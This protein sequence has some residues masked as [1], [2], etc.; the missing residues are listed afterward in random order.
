[1][2]TWG[3]PVLL[4]VT[5]VNQ[6]PVVSVLM[7]TEPVYVY[8][9]TQL[10]AS[11]WASL[12]A[13]VV[14]AWIGN[15]GSYWLGRTAG[16]AVVG[17]MKV[18]QGAMARAKGMFDRHGAAFVVVA[19]LIWPI[20]TLTQVMSGAWGMRPWTFLVA[21]GLGAVLAIAQYAL[22]GWASA[23]GL[24]ALG[25]RPEE[26]LLAWLGPYLV[27]IGVLAT[28]LLGAVLIL[29][30]GRGAR[31]VRAAYV[32][33][34]ALGM[35]LAV[36]LGALTGHTGAAA[37]EAPIP[38]A[39]A[40]RALDE[41]LVART[42]STPLHSAQPVNLVLVGV[43]DPGAVLEGLGW[44]RNRTYAGEPLNAWDVVGLTLRGLPP[45]S[46]LLLEGASSDL[47]WQQERGTVPRVQLR[48]WPVAVPEGAP[49]TFLGSVV[50][51]DAITLRLS[52]RVPTL[53][54]DLWPATDEARDEEAAAL[55]AALP[56]ASVAP[57]GPETAFVAPDPASG[58][59]P[60]EAF[61]AAVANEF[62]S[63]GRAAELRAPG[64]PSLADLC[65][66]LSP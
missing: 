17:R 66:G 34:L 53:A 39:T 56:G 57:V 48:L 33:L 3:W 37:A 45:A 16:A 18:G 7:P 38:L 13:C 49:P 44:L 58:E 4:L 40:C 10:P 28:V 23:A 27:L 61:P 6:L 59:D 35:L 29:W 1:M 8:L 26:S 25:L 65:A 36:N 43:E 19:Q 42:G 46:S 54:Y 21:S 2:L 41:T 30:R 63:D 32:A 47:S 60:F 24:A 22:I 9:G 52:G 31:P 5:I 14:G 11:G 64:A 15:Q 62:F 55:A 12:I 51:V 20:A 50:Q